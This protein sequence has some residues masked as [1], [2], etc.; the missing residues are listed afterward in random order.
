MVQAA[1]FVYGQSSYWHCLCV[2][3]LCHHLCR[4]AIKQPMKASKTLVVYGEQVTEYRKWS[5]KSLVLFSWTD[6]SHSVVW[7]LI[8]SGLLLLF[9]RYV[10]LKV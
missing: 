9:S 5:V 3:H 4:K 10:N 1:W 7:I 8:L 2:R 6:F